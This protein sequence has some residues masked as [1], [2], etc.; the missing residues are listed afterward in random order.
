MAGPTPHTSSNDGRMDRP[1]GRHDRCGCNTRGRRENIGP[2]ICRSGG[3]DVPDGLPA[4]LT[5]PWARR[6][7]LV[8][9]DVKPA[10]RSPFSRLRGDLVT[11]SGCG[12]CWPGLECLFGRWPPRSAGPSSS[13]TLCMP[14]THGIVWQIRFA[15]A[16]Q[17][18]AVMDTGRR[19]RARAALELGIASASARIAGFAGFLL[20]RGRGW[21]LRWPGF[22]EAVPQRDKVLRGL[23]NRGSKMG[24]CPS[25]H[26]CE[27]TPEFGR[28]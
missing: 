22:A 2:G 7:H 16:G 1:G 6:G 4:N 11:G 23:R 13:R 19:F 9:S 3:R 21:T 26:I 18:A 24:R 17:R 25:C 12:M 10:S 20:A 27:G 5:R 14:G 15:P 28:C 8:I